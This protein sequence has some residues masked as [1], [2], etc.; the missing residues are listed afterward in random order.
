[1]S[2]LYETHTFSL[3]SKKCSH[4]YN[5]Q[6]KNY[7]RKL[8]E[9]SYNINMFLYISLGGKG[10]FQISDRIKNPDGTDI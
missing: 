6:I 3:H 5:M 4:K 2:S 1:M 9:H 8:N 10:D 7:L